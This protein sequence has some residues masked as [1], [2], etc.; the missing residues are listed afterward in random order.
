MPSP[1]CDVLSDRTV[2]AHLDVAR[3]AGGGLGDDN[4]LADEGGS[5]GGHSAV[6]GGRARGK[7]ECQA[8][9]AIE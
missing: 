8:S 3:L 6:G 7:S 5:H 1:T 2:G 9:I 4:A